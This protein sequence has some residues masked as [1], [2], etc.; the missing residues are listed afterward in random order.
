MVTAIAPYPTIKQRSVGLK[1]DVTP[2]E[3]RVAAGG[4]AP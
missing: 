4:D 2:Q 3:G 1:L